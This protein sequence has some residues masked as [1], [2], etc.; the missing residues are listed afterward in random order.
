LH[1]S[2]DQYSNER[3]AEVRGI[4]YK[5]V[6]DVVERQPVRVIWPVICLIVIHLVWLLRARGV[7]KRAREAG[8]SFDEFDEGIQWQA[9]GSNICKI[10]SCVFKRQRM[11]EESIG[12]DA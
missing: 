8:K 4:T 9:K 6:F 5:A 12:Y 3:D 7:S 11:F 10:L 1:T 2:V